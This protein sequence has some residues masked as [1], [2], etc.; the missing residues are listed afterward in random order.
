MKS[1]SKT[2]LYGMKDTDKSI[3]FEYILKKCQYTIFKLSYYKNVKIFLRYTSK[4]DNHFTI[5]SISDLNE[6]KNNEVMIAN[7]IIDRLNLGLS[8]NLDK[9]KSFSLEYSYEK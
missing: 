6:I 1:H 4:D 5:L 2:L 7:Y 9:I 3:P 8:H